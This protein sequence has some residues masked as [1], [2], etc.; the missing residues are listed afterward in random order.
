[1]LESGNE[2]EFD[3]DVSMS[4]RATKRISVQKKDV[5]ALPR[6]RVQSEVTN[7]AT[8]NTNI[9]EELT[10]TA[11]RNNAAIVNQAAERLAQLDLNDF[12]LPDHVACSD[13]PGLRGS[14]G[15][16]RPCLQVHP[17]LFFGFSF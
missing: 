9:N 11:L 8:R 12:D 15:T 14:W 5:A 13:P 17:S 2:E 7:Q 10:V 16:L 6:R 1:M 4:K 3:V